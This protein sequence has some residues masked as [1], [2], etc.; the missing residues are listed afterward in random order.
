MLPGARESSIYGISLDI[1]SLIR[2][3]S[4][5]YSDTRNKRGELASSVKGWSL[6]LSIVHPCSPVHP[7]GP[8]MSANSTRIHYWAYRSRLQKL[9]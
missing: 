9:Q 1:Q 7:S 4:E 3:G 6:E 2:S 8:A 5:N